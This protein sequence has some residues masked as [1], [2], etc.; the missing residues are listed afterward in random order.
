MR[1]INLHRLL[2][3]FTVDA[4]SRLSAEA[5]GGAEMPFELAE[6]RGAQGVPL[7]CYRPLTDEFIQSRMGALRALPSH[8]PAARGLTGCAALDVYL[9]E[10]GVKSPA[11][12]RVR[13]E[14]ALAVFLGCVFSERTGFGFEPA[15]F[16]AAY[17]EL[18]RAVYEGHCTATV[19]APLRGVALD[20][21]TTEV[22]LGQGLSLIR[23]D[24]LADA[25]DQAVWGDGDEPNVV[26]LVAIDER[27][28][29]HSP[30]A[31]ARTQFRRVLSAL[32]LFERGGYAIGPVGWARTEAGSWRSVAIGVNGRPRML[33]LVP[34][35]QEDELRA[36]FRLM[37]R[38]A[39]SGELG[40][41][42]ARFEMGCERL[43][44][45]EAL[46]DYLLAL[47]AVLEP[48]GPAS[49]R[50]AQRL[51]VICARPEEQGA[52]AKRT[53]SAISLERTLVTGVSGGGA[54][55]DALVGELAEHLRSILRDAL[56]GHLP[57][58]LV[59][60]ADGLLAE[61]SAA[62]GS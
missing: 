39:P 3:A 54:R 30:V 62:A 33:T 10:H 61:A 42:L 8:R 21:A 58:D 25:P 41:A 32:R 56:C 19:I 59:A 43:A 49:G 55:V 44:P 31:I 26:A 47:R 51:A 15:Q 4:S 7:Y 1:N 37:T 24:A 12:E 16:E 9:R 40:W 34:A 45:V 52:L 60:V 17:A 2:E 28:A 27:R 20:P 23:G 38:R 50:L 6:E 5:A 53:A 13:C 18:E 48:E 46:T 22:S 35:A 29:D 36:F 57:V 11:D 14:L